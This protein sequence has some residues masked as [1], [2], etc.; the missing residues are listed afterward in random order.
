MTKGARKELLFAVEKR[1]KICYNN[2]AQELDAYILSW[3]IRW[4]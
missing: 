1:H 2:Y 3:S 4:R